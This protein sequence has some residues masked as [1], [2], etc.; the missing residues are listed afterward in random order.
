MRDRPVLYSSQPATLLKGKILR[1]DVLWSALWCPSNGQDL[2]KRHFCSWKN[3][4]TQLLNNFT[5]RRAALAVKLG[6]DVMLV[7]VSSS[8]VQRTRA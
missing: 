3:F 5:D 8:L 4:A 2:S 1:Y 7:D 6:S